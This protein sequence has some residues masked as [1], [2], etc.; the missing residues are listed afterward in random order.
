MSGKLS[1]LLYHAR[2]GQ[3]IFPCHWVGEDGICSCGEAGCKSPGKHPLVSNGFYTAST[4]QEQIRAWHEKGPLANWALRTGK[5][6]V[7]DIDPRNNGDVSWDGLRTD[8][9]EPLETIRVKS[10]GGGTHYWFASADGMVIDSKEGVWL[11]MDVKAAGGYVLIPPSKTKV[12]YRFEI[13][14]NDVPELPEPPDWILDKLNHRQKS[15]I[16]LSAAR[17]VR[18]GEKH[19]TLITMAAKM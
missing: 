6:I 7:I 17:T 13:G 9:P 14:P 18:Q 19:Q 2:H 8:H 3:P 4:D 11:G 15:E 10:G 5:I 16:Q 12:E 1:R